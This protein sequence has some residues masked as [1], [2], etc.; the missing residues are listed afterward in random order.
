[1]SANEDN[2][3]LKVGA[4]IAA[5]SLGIWSTAKRVLRA[6]KPSLTETAG[7]TE[8]ERP[9]GMNEDTLPAEPTVGDAAKLACYRAFVKGMDNR[10]LSFVILQVLFTSDRAITEEDLLKN[11]RALTDSKASQNAFEKARRDLQ[12]GECI[13]PAR[14]Q[15]HWEI[16]SN[17]RVLLADHYS[18]LTNGKLVSSNDQQ[19][20]CLEGVLGFVARSNTFRHVLLALA[21]AQ[22]PLSGA[23]VHQ[24]A[25]VLA[26]PHL[27]KQITVA[28][29]EK[30]LKDLTRD[31]FVEEYD[32]GMYTIH[33]N[34]LNLMQCI[35]E[36]SRTRRR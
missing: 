3:W 28:G 36:R 14:L 24:M 1:M 34:G 12:Y 17:G 23:D 15:K 30:L 8:N 26:K 7:G 9:T 32:P 11:A 20:L 25:V 33:A 35:S 10:R 21:S 13:Q 2:F 22:S 29:V 19:L 27:G 31:P 4:A 5:I 18:L 16:R 6:R